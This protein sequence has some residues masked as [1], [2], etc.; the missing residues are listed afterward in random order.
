MPVHTLI[1]ISGKRKYRR[2]QY[3]NT[4]HQTVGNVLSKIKLQK[5]SN[6]STNIR[7]SPTPP[8]QEN[9]E[10]QPKSD[11]ETSENKTGT[12]VQGDEIGNTSST[13]TQF[14]CR[15]CQ[16]EFQQ[17]R[18]LVEH[19]ALS[20]FNHIWDADT[21]ASSE[22][23]GNNVEYAASN[24][25]NPYAVPQTGPYDCHLCYDYHTDSRNKFIVH[26]ACRH[27]VLK[28]M[29]GEYAD[30]KVD[31]DNEY[32]GG[33]GAAIDDDD[34][35][36]EGQGIAFDIDDEMEEEDDIGDGEDIDGEDEFEE[37]TFQTADQDEVTVDEMDGL[38]VGEIDVP[39]DDENESDDEV[40]IQ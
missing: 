6:R 1:I 24:D 37:E 30:F 34:N 17:Y 18:F 33:G 28:P 29:M 40:Q 31:G 8:I 35:D 20:H 36:I 15:I 38:N 7:R 11:E 14:L 39:S 19:M 26:L 27:D 10:T 9:L 21:N 23:G 2:N 3:D 13:P 32:D 22:N 5:Q 12:T 16:E 4:Q 25:E